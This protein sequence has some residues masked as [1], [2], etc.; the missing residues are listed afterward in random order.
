VKVVQGKDLEVDYPVG[1]RT[2][3]EI[4]P[5]IGL[6]P[7]P[8]DRDRQADHGE[9]DHKIKNSLHSLPI[10]RREADNTRSPTP[11]RGQSVS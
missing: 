11:L 3:S 7:N 9:S 5:G 4:G 8:L 10:T 2:I 6:S 1:S